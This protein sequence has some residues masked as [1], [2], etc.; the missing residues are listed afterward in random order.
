M[1]IE[2]LKSRTAL[3]GEAMQMRNCIL[4]YEI[5][6][7][8]DEC[9]AYRLL[10]PERATVLIDKRAGHWSIAE[11]MLEANSSQVRSHTWR[12]LN[13]WLMDATT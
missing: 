10:K 2:A 11:A 5:N 12:L 6:I 8:H 9:Y 4:S 13:D 7:Y 1:H 3:K